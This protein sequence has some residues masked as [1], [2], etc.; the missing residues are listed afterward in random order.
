MHQHSASNWP[1]PLDH[2]HRTEESMPLRGQVVGT[3]L[4]RLIAAC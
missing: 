4:L 3:K 1:D 2:T